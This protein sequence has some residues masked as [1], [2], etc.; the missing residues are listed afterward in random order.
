MTPIFTTSMEKTPAARG[1]PKRAAKQALMPHMTAIFLS[2]S[3]RRTTLAS[4]VPI[5]PPIWSAAPSRPAE[6]LTRWLRMVD[7][8]IRGPV[9]T[10]ISSPAEMDSRTMLV[11]RFFSS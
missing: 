6:A 9:A 4:R 5:L 10:V 1:V 3:S 7:T 2:L 11:P 8:K